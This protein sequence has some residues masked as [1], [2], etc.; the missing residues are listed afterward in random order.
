MSGLDLHELAM[1]IR[2]SKLSLFYFNWDNWYHSEAVKNAFQLMMFITVH[3]FMYVV[4]L[5]DK[6]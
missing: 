1:V 6:I 4:E 5:D 3:L 2:R